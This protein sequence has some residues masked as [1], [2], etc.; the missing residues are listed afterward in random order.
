MLDLAQIL[1]R[2]PA[3]VDSNSGITSGIT[4]IINIREVGLS[5]AVGFRFLFFWVFVAERP[6]GEPP[7]TTNLNDPQ[8]YVYYAKNSHSARWERWGYIG[9]VLKWLI[10]TATLSI[11][12]LQI[13]WR[14]AVRHFG[15]LYMLEATIEILVTAL[16]I[17]KVA[18]NI[19]LSPDTPWWKPFRY[20]GAPLVTLLINLTLG[21]GQLALCEH[22]SILVHVFPLSYSK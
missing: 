4:A 3:N 5:V 22:I 21:I 15:T 17:L 10:L 6:R 9:H 18:L 1:A 12:I 7:P 11:P 20:Y 2:G 16:L 8:N 14:I 19:F 13:I